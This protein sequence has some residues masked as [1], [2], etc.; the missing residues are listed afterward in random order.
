MPDHGYRH[1]EDPYVGDQVGDV[2][3]V[4]KRD[5]SQTGAVHSTIPISPERPAEQEQC[6]SDTNSPGNDEGSGCED[7]L[8]KDW[9]DKHSPV[10][11]QDAQLHED[12]GK[13][14]EMAEDEV[15]LPYHH[16]VILGDKDNMPTHTMRRAYERQLSW[17]LVLRT[18]AYHSPNH[19]RIVQSDMSNAPC[20]KMDTWLR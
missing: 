19:L 1:Q 16:L 18:E 5:D 11:G 2:G 8:A 7:D 15:A 4:G 12:Q 6:D 20:Q 9:V 14:V 10:E 17:C 3:E 13:V